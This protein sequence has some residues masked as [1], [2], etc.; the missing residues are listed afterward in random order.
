MMEAKFYVTSRLAKIAHTDEEI[1]R[2]TGFLNEIQAIPE[3]QFKF[4]AYC[5]QW[6]LAPWMFLQMNRLNLFSNL[7]PEVREEFEKVYHA[8]KTENEYRSRE[9]LNFLTEFENEGIEVALLKGNAFIHTIYNDAGYK[10]MNDFDMLIH[11]SDWP[12]VQEIY[13]KLNYIPLGN[14]WNGEKGDVAKF[15]HTGLSFL[16][17]NY[18]C[19][20]G[21]QWGLKSPTSNYKVNLNDLWNSTIDFNYHDLTVKLLSPEYNILHLILHMG[22]Y[23]CGIRDCMDIYNLL[24]KEKEIDFEKLS[25]IIHDSNTRDKAWFTLQLADLCS[26]TIDKSFLNGLKPKSK[27]FIVKRADARLKMAS[28]T[29]DM[30]LS[31]NDQFHEV[32]MLVFYFSLFHVF[33]KKCYFFLKLVQRM[34]F[35]PKEIAYKL[36]DLDGN[37]LLFQKVKSRLKA[38]YFM[39]SLIGEEIGLK[40]T[41]LLFVKLALETT[42]SVRFYVMKKETYF[43]YLRKQN[44]DPKEIQRVVKGIQ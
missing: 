7:S 23:K 4:F 43:E 2:I 20:T 42:L 12:L 9:A 6:K 11:Q 26:G 38:P 41:I 17:P 24:V 1:A 16:S 44:I 28:R 29:G 19:I 14:G 32:E 40:I 31:Y 8:V 34:F 10:K 5:K 35:P 15:S 36:S 18:H 37:S 21:T 33:H 39:F 25:K 22:T 27:S 13:R 30:Q 3:A